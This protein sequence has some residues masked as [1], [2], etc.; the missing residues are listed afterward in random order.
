ML[1]VLFASLLLCSISLAQLASVTGRVTDQSGAVVPAAAVAATAVET[2]VLSKTQTNDDG[3][4]TLPALTPG[5][6]DLTVEKIGFA[7]VRQTGLTL[8]VQQVAR[9]DV[10]L[11]VGQTTES[12]QVNAQAPLL[13]SES[14]T[15]G[16]VVNNQQVTE[17]PLLGRN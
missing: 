16:Q 8:T 10:T 5:R 12:V 13:E 1:R 14:T 15:L 17:L 11:A 3:Y 4:Y 6:Y 9:L 2:G 7:P